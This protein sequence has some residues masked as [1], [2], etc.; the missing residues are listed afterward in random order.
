MV[1]TTT[2]DRSKFS[3]QPMADISSTGCEFIHHCQIEISKLKEDRA[4]LTGQLI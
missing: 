3:K 1:T 4:S 2:F